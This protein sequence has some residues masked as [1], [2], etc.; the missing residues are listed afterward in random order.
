MSR[1]AALPFPASDDTS[2]TT[3]KAQ[4]WLELF[5]SAAPDRMPMFLAQAIAWKEQI[6]AHGD[7]APAIARDLAIAATH[8]AASRSS[9]QTS[10]RAPLEASPLERTSE[11]AAAQ[12]SSSTQE[13]AA[14]AASCSSP[15][16]SRSGRARPSPAAPR[17][18][19]RRTE[20]SPLPP[21]SSQLLPGTRLV[22]T[23]AGKTHVVEVTGS[24][25]TYE[26]EQFSS[27][28]AVAKH[29]TGTHWN[30]LL[31]FGLRRRKVYPAKASACG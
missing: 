12:C 23:H 11:A 16:P 9:R 17:S 21:A 29:I 18:S 27:L 6:I 2:V 20:P 22:K 14:A 15:T 8:V 13:S 1:K 30:G 26:G 19:S 10:A 25:F 31:F 28:S 4:R 3:N 24:G 5:G 7:V